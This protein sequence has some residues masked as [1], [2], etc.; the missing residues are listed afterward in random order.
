MSSVA[1][2][3][4]RCLGL[5][6]LKRREVPRSLRGK[7]LSPAPLLSIACCSAPSSVCSPLSIPPHK[8]RLSRSLCGPPSTQPALAEIRGDALMRGTAETLSFVD[9]LWG[10]LENLTP[11]MNN[12]KQFVATKFFNESWWGFGR[13]RNTKDTCWRQKNVKSWR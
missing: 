9:L 1:Y 12:G 3:L 7:S 13:V 8:H 6:N 11:S 5:I 10:A 2:L 4:R